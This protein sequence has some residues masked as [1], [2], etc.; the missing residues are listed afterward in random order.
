MT[1]AVLAVSFSGC[2]L[3]GAAVGLPYV[4]C[5]K[6]ARIEALVRAVAKRE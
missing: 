1:P 5:A 4:M 3:L 2:V 6:L